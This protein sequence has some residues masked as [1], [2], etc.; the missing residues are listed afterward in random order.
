MHTSPAALPQTVGLRAR[1][2]QQT[3]LA[4]SDTALQ[5]FARRGF[6]AVTIDD[7][8]DAVGVSRR[9]FFRYFPSKEAV[10]FARQEARLA[11]FEAHLASANAD[12]A[13]GANARVACVLPLDVVI[14]AVLEMAARYQAERDAVLASHAVL[15]AARGLAAA[16][17]QLDG[18]WEAAI[19]AALR[20]QLGELPAMVHA[21]AIIGTVRAG[22]R[23]WFAADASF[24]LVDFG[25][26]AFA[27]LA[28]GL[29]LGAPAALDP[30]SVAGAK[31]DAGA[32]LHVEHAPRSL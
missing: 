20:P 1:K 17:Q 10:F 27:C 9:T 8:T 2:R 24:D 12:A 14:A 15:V 5:L 31:L 11:A 16:D 26:Q 32:T 22:L 18:R 4:L 30:T 13:L 3:L 29:P 6:D 19:V 28:A 21:A 7:I 25:Q 23:R